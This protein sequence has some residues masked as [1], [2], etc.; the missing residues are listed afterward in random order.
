MQAS[1]YVYGICLF[2][3]FVTLRFHIS[4]LP[5]GRCLEL[6]ESP[7]KGGVQL[8]RLHDLWTND[9]EESEFHIYMER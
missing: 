6:L 3:T 2:V 4:I 1:I 7:R 5:T 8:S 9:E